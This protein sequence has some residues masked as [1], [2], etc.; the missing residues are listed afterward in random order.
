MLM[1]K[2]EFSKKKASILFYRAWKQKR[3]ANYKIEIVQKLKKKV[4]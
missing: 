1:L 3:V 2:Q 4:D